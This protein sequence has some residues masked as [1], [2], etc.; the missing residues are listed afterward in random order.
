VKNG[1][2][3]YGLSLKLLRPIARLLGK[4]MKPE[5]YRSRGWHE[6][7]L[8]REATR[9]LDHDGFGIFTFVPLPPRV[10]GRLL[11]CELHCGGLSFLKRFAVN[12]KLTALVEKST[13]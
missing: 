13:R 1:T 3:L 8:T 12:Y 2:S 6:R 11:Q 9:I 4:K 10:V 7:E 5:F